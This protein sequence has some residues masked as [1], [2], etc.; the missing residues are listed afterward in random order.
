MFSFVNSTYQWF[1][2]IYTRALFLNKSWIHSRL[3][4][5]QHMPCLQHSSHTYVFAKVAH[6]CKSSILV[7]SKHPQ[8]L[9]CWDLTLKILMRTIGTYRGHSFRSARSRRYR[10]LP[11]C[12]LEWQTAPSWWLRTTYFKRTHTC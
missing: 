4:K 11:R 6:S 5:K 7:I 2:N 12:R 3:L 1:P 9:C 10:G 8:M